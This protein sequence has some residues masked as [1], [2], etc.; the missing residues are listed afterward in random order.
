[1]RVACAAPAPSWAVRPGIGETL[2]LEY[3]AKDA[4]YRS[5][6]VREALLDYLSA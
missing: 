3:R 1:L 6:E 5:R 2:V 4:D